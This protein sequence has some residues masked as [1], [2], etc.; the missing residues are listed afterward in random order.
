MIP[1]GAASV[2]VRLSRAGDFDGWLALFEAVAG[3]ALWL[4]A[5]A[6]LD[7]EARRQFFDRC[8]TDAGAAIFLAELGGDLVGTVSVSLSGGLADLGMF[9]GRDHRRAGVGSALV[10]TAVGG[11]G[12]P[13][14]TSPPTSPPTPGWLPADPSTEVPAHPR[15]R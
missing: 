14:M 7:P 10:E 13:S 5:E 1:P 12:A 8:Q 6:P 11:P 4:G 9:V 3:E 2:L 15:T